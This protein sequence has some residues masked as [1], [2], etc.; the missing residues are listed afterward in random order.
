MAYGG[1]AG[2]VHEKIEAMSNGSTVRAQSTTSVTSLTPP[3]VSPRLAH[4]TIVGIPFSL[5]LEHEHEHISSRLLILSSFPLSDGSS[6]KPNFLR[7]EIGGRG[8]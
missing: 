8:S 3:S 2:C 7:A 5:P 1:C 4:H 6:R